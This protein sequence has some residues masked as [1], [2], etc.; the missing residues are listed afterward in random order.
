M[1][2]THGEEE[3]VKAAKLSQTTTSLPNKLTLEKVN[4]APK[5]SSLKPSL[6]GEEEKV[7]AEKLS[8][9]TT[10]RQYPRQP[11]SLAAAIRAVLS[12][13]RF[14]ESNNKI[15]EEFMEFVVC[16]STTWSDI[17]VSKIKNE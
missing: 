10:S 8:Q 15:R 4:F 11:T 1:A 7:K 17:I 12:V 5:G 2:K 3:K 14:S 13:L 16:H 6:N 9:T